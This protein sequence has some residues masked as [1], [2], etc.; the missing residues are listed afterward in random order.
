M[1]AAFAVYGYRPR[2]EGA[3]VAYSAPGKQIAR[4]AVEDDA[5]VIFAVFAANGLGTADLS[6]PTIQRELLHHQFDREGWECSTMLNLLDQSEDLYFDR[7]SQIRMERWSSGRIALVGDAAYAPSLLAGQGAALAMTGAY[8]LARE[9]DVFGR[10]YEA[11]F[12]RY[13]DWMRPLVERKQRAGETLAGAFVP[14]TRFG[15]F[16]RNRASKVLSI[17]W[18]AGLVLGPVLRDQLRSP[19]LYSP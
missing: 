11:A 13:E 5:T 17:P 6:D 19:G 3:Y 16:L 8:V 4:F 18:L 9:L 14:R 2:D 12:S 7:V 10:E 15:I 1:A